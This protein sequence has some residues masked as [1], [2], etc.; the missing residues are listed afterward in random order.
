[1]PTKQDE[2][3]FQ[4]RATVD[5]LYEDAKV[6]WDLNKKQIV[7]LGISIDAYIICRYCRG[8]KIFLCMID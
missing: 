7:Y 1:M 5:D 2:S 6:K 4:D 3:D 8:L